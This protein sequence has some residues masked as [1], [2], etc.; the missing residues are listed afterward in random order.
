[1]YMYYTERQNKKKQCYDRLESFEFR[2][3]NFLDCQ[4]FKDLLGCYRIDVHK[5]KMNKDYVF[6]IC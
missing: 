5:Y 1:M 2:G 6:I 4:F 3:A